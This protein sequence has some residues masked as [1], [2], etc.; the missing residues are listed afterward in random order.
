MIYSNSMKALPV[1]SQNLVTN[2]VPV[3]PNLIPINITNYQ[4]INSFYTNNSPPKNDVVLLLTDQNVQYKNI[5]PAPYVL[6]NRS[7]YGNEIINTSI[8][9]SSSLTKYHSQ[10]KII[11][12]RNRSYENLNILNNIDYGIS[13]QINNEN[14]NNNLIVDNVVN[15]EPQKY[16]KSKIS[17]IPHPT[18]NKKRRQN[19]I[20]NFKK[21]FIN[22]QFFPNQGNSQNFN[23]INNDIN[24]NNINTLLNNT[25]DTS[26]ND[27]FYGNLFPSYPDIEPGININL[28]EYEVLNQI[29]QGSEGAI[30]VVKWKKNNKKYALKK[31]TIFLETTFQKRKSEN[32]SLRKFID[33]TGCDGLIK[34]YGNFSKMNEYGLYEF[35]ELMELAEKDWEKEIIRRRD[36]QQFYQEYELMDIFKY[37]IKTFALLQNNKITHRDIKPQNIMMINGQLKICDFGNARILKRDG[38]IIQK[39]RG[40]ELFMSPILFK[41]YRS[42]KQQIKHNTF[43]SDVYS[44]GVCFL[45]AASLSFD[46]PNIIRQVYDMKIIRKVLC[47][48]LQRRYSQNLINLIYTMLQIDENKRPDFVELEL[49]IL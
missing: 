30:Y 49:M 12:Q 23:T 14:I 1:F 33:S 38:I 13:E 11:K 24:N 46:G 15:Y 41:G 36:S 28:S 7:I 2:I 8:K 17:K 4:P 40:S 47:Q 39:I 20:P 10:G 48:Q 26:S 19:L 25:I 42:G 9:H 44:L 32:V 37:L 18:F 43:K 21:Q 35:Y 16:Y 22:Y 27:I 6:P 31:C 3:T 29:G 34:I 5:T 45:L